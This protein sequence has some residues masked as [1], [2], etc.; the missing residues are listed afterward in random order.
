MNIFSCYS[1]CGIRDIPSETDSP[2]TQATELEDEQERLIKE[3]C[4]ELLVLFTNNIDPGTFN[5]SHML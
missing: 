5:D 4:E 1:A 3:G 2:D